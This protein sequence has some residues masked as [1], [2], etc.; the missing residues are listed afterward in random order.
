MLPIKSERGMSI[1]SRPDTD[2][3]SG[4]RAAAH[5]KVADGANDTR[6]QRDGGDRR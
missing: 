4:R 2:A 6:G 5:R 3:A 1:L